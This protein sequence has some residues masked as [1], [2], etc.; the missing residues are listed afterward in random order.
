MRRHFLS[1]L[2]VFLFYEPRKK[3]LLTGLRNL[4]NPLQFD[5]DERYIYVH[6]WEAFYSRPRNI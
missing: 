1:N 2:Y 5:K 4:R 6:Q 3:V